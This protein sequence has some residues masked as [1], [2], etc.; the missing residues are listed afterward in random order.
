MVGLKDVADLAGVSAS[1][2]SRVLAN[3]S[4]VSKQ[5]RAK[6]WKAI[7]QLDYRPNTLAQSLKTG[8]SQVLALVI[9]S[10]QNL[11][12]PV[13]ARGAE[14]AA[15]EKGYTLVLC[16]TDEDS[17]VEKQYLSLLQSHLVSGFIIATMKPSSEHIIKL[18]ESGVPIV[19]TSR[20]SNKQIDTILIDNKDAARRA[21]KHLIDTGCKHIAIAMGNQDLDLYKARMAGY[22]QALEDAGIDFNEDLVLY[23]PGDRQ[24]LYDQVKDLI[25]SDKPFDGLFATNDQRAFIAMRAIHDLDKKIPEEISVVGFDDV[26][27]SSLMEPPLTT[28]T[29]PLYEI[30]RKA[31]ERCFEIIKY[32]EEHGT[33]PVAEVSIL[34][35]TL[36][37]RRSTKEETKNV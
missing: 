15:R 8:S 32:K 24:E 26:D 31:V 1:T 10:I 17:D 34:D 28:V 5:T 12:F 4:Y 18:R 13:L 2:V 21:V 7:E 6:V 33:L 3:K 23:N 9:P 22:R 11:M 25:Q 36:T 19:L 27:M 29:Q 14:D 35:T 30:G 37:I 20:S 16:N